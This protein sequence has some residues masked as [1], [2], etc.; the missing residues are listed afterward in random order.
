MERTDVLTPVTSLFLPPFLYAETHYRFRF[1]PSYLKAPFPEIIADAPHRIEPGSP[2]PLLLLAKDAHRY[3]ALLKTATAT[4]RQDGKVL[5]TFPLLP[6]PPALRQ[7]LWWQV[8]PIQLGN[9]RGWIECDIAFELEAAAGIL[10]FSNDNHRTSSKKSLRIYV[11]SDTLPSLPRLVLG[12]GHAHSDHTSDQVEFGAP[13]GAAQ[14]M[15]LAMGLGFACIT[16]HSY[17]LDDHL[18]D[19]LRNHHQTP[20][21]HALHADVDAL[22]GSSRKFAFIRGEEVSCRTADGRNVHVLVLGNRRFIP[23]S[24]D[25]AER[26]LRT[27][28]EHSIPEVV[29]F[30]EPCSAAFGAHVLEPVP[31]LQRILLGRG[32]WHRA[33]LTVRG[34]DGFQFANG[35]RDE[36]FTAG[37]QEWIRLLLAGHRCVTLAG[38]DAHGNFNRFRQ[39]GIP[40]LLIRE[41]LEQIWGATRTGVFVDGVDEKGILEAIRAG[42]SIISDGPVLDLRTVNGGASLIGT[43]QKEPQVSFKVESATSGEYGKVRIL[44]IIQGVVG[45]KEM[46]LVEKRGPL[47]DRWTDTFHLANDRRGYVRAEL[48]TDAS[49]SAY[50]RSHFGMTNPIWLEPA[51]SR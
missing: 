3:P 7:Q 41:S 47:P 25:S 11:A 33:D 50:G 27:R 4:I 10:R 34:L 24:G 49:T 13:L 20:K 32:V 12:E 16:D 28:S 26:W 17:D 29:S 21:W 31:F 46:T 39:I 38:D 42:H 22:N 6:V 30:K 19:Y 45:G 23:G 14:Q 2:L 48:W 5:G 35:K 1:F 36:G 18:E 51:D 15:S 44:R 8:V 37:Y 43:E 40:F 9:V